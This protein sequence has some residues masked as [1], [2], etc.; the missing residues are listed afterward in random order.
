VSELGEERATQGWHPYA[1]AVLFLLVVMA[2]VAVAVP[3]EGG[4]ISGDMAVKFALAQRSGLQIAG[5][6]RDWLREA[7]SAYSEV[8]RKEPSP[9]VI[10]RLGVISAE[11]SRPAMPVFRRLASPKFLKDR[12]SAER[13]ALA[14][15][16]RMWRDIYGVVNAAPGK[17]AEY[18]RRIARLELGPARSLA[19]SRMYAAARLPEAAKKV[20]RTGEQRA[21][22]QLHLLW[23]LMLFWFLIGVAGIPVLLSFFRNSRCYRELAEEEPPP[24]TPSQSTL[25]SSLTTFLFVLLALQLVGKAIAGDHPI[26]YQV[27]A[28]FGSYV[29]AGLVALATLAV[30]ARDEGSDLAAIGLTG[31]DLGRN[32]VIGLLGYGAILVVVGISLGATQIIVKLLPE[33]P[34]PTHPAASLI[35]EAASSPVIALI[36][37]LVALMA[38]FF[39]EVFFRGVLYHAL[40]ARVGAVAAILL[41]GAAFAA[42][43]PQGPLGFL[44]LFVLGSGFAVLLAVRKSL[45]P[46]MV[47]HS[48]N[49]TLTFFAAVLLLGN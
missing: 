36:F 27:A 49:N 3:R 8:A 7:Y 19:L 47:A 17:A 25:W 18:R 45:L 37:V 43:H 38:P 14:K 31:R 39:E 44:P 9:A 21:A 34:S 48:L 23:R 29:L 30:K 42:I 32:I 6:E 12:S 46:S 22:R 41:T 16:L 26:E 13:E 1:L 35:G 10:R 40:R 5:K 24:N 28:A 33:L 2:L 4:S 20:A 11:L 15:E